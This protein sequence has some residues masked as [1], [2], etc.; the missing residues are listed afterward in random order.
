MKYSKKINK[1]KKS[2]LR[3]WA[4]IKK[5]YYD[6]YKLIRI[7]VNHV[8]FI[9][10]DNERVPLKFLWTDTKWPAQDEL[11]LSWASQCAL[12]VSATSGKRSK[13]GDAKFLNKFNVVK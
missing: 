1:N 13:T 4:V 11:S 5:Y 12:I 9:S 10:I 3:I 7:I 6:D 8:T 2:D